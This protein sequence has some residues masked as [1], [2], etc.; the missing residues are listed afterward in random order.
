MRISTEFRNT[1]QPANTGE[2]FKLL[3]GIFLFLAAVAVMTVLVLM[4]LPGFIIKTILI[5]TLV[6]MG[7]GVILVAAINRIMEQQP[8][9]TGGG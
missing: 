9:H 5:Y 2:D 4:P 6:F 3:L 1:N 7:L 8:G